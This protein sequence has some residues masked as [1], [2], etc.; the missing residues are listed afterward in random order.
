MKSRK[1]LLTLIFSMLL[2]PFTYAQQSPAGVWQIK[3][4]KTG[5]KRALVRITETNRVLNGT[6]I[7]IY[8]Q[9]GDTGICNKCPGH[10]K[11]KPVV[12]LPFLW[13]V[14]AQGHDVWDKGQLLDPKSGKIYRVKLSLDKDELL[15]RGYIGVSV[16]GR[17][18]TWFRAGNSSK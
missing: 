11:D 1:A 6:I 2:I 4:E 12:G 17:T 3:D 9:P 10:F 14:K 5:K 7:K 15:V 18:Q 16:L 8:R 13:G